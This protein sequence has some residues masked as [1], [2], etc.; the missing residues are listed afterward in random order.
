MQLCI[1]MSLSSSE[2]VFFIFSVL[3]SILKVSQ[4]QF[5][6]TFS[7][8]EI[9]KWDLGEQFFCISFSTFMVN[10]FSNTVSYLFWA[11]R[12]KR[13]ILKLFF[14]PLLREF[15]LELADLLHQSLCIMFCCA[16]HAL[17]KHSRKQVWISRVFQLLRSRLPNNNNKNVLEVGYTVHKANHRWRICP[18]QIHRKNKLILFFT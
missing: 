1:V 9:V 7:E 17:L 15:N 18:K 4:M 8:N 12:S 5:N 2:T 10:F 6:N 3:Y 11:D 13:F 14:F 16:Y